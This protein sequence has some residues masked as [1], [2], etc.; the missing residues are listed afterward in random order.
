MKILV[1]QKSVVHL[2][3]WFKNYVRTYKH[4]DRE[5]QLNIDLKEDHTRRVGKE[6]VFLGKQLGLSDD[7]LHLA[8][9]IALL[10]D[11]GRFEQYARYRTFMDGKSEDHAELGIKI[12]VKSGI[13]KQF[14]AAI[15]EVILGAIRYHNRSSL[16][17]EGTKTFLFFSKLLRDADKLDIWKVVIDNYHRKDGKRNGALELDLPDTAGF[18]GEVYQDLINKR[19]VDLRHIKN[20]NDLK[21]LQASWVFDINFQPTFDCIR[22]RRY[23]EMI[24]DVLPK[25]KEMEEI[26]DITHSFLV[27]HAVPV[28]FKASPRPPRLSGRTDGC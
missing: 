1:D 6:I 18:S 16:P 4:N 13:L 28:G 11:V 27:P 19:I 15:K 9:I 20:L 25:S 14:D 23:L 26:F 24:R 22:K 10:H 7:E 17:R 21:L 5:S 2:K 8:E 3:K 12:L